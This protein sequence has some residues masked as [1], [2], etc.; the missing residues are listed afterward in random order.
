MPRLPDVTDARSV[1]VSRR[2]VTQDRSGLIVA[3]SIGRA[4]EGIAQ[5]G[6]QRQERTDQFAYAKAKSAF[7]QAGIEARRALENDN[8]YATYESR[9]QE[10][11]QKGLGAAL[12]L[13]EDPDD[14]AL[15]E[16]DAQLDVQRGLDA[17]RGRARVV[18]VDRARADLSGV[19]D[20]NRAAALAA[21]D[22]DTQ[23][24]I[25]ENTLDMIGAA[26]G[27]QYIGAEDAAKLRQEWTRSFALGLL[28]TMPAEERVAVLSKP[29]GTPASFLHADQRAKLLEQ[30]RAE[31]DETRIRASSQEASDGI[32]A[33]HTD[34]ASALR[35]ARAISDPQVRDATVSR[36]N[37]RFNEIDVADREEHDRIMQSASVLVE[38]DGNLDGI[39][40]G[41]LNKLTIHE[42]SALEARAAQVSGNVEPSTDWGLYYGLRGA[43]STDP[44]EFKKMDL[45]LFRSQLNE[46]EFKQIVGLQMDIREGKDAAVLSGVQTQHQIVNGTLES[47]G[48][49]TGGLK[50]AKFEEMAQ[51]EANFRREVDQRVIALQAETGRKATTQDV[52]AIVDDIAIRKVFVEGGWFSGDREQLTIELDEDEAGRIYVPVDEIPA[53]ERKALENLASSFGK[54]PTKDRL[55]RAYAQALAG[56]REAMVEIMRQ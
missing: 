36:V 56:D 2:G 24:A 32:L 8:D 44:D 26:E 53:E 50:G 45:M 31:H 34:R 55:Q 15:F 12:S 21:G 20:G 38:Q 47:L 43:A 40:P 6:A 49:R 29:D 27:R 4:A 18:E 14:R 22:E 41:L 48:I 9:Y 52:Q 46:A 17:V 10:S 23:R 33:E 19:L 11:M 7:L 3:G 54:V 25:V 13:I 30:A 35:A 37:Q 28:D 51:R 16:L 1:P 5:I 42:R 39:D